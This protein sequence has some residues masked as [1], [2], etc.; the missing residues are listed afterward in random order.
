MRP[1]LTEWRI[2]PSRACQTLTD[3]RQTFPLKGKRCKCQLYK[4]ATVVNLL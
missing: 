3:L 1:S 4:Q 2:T